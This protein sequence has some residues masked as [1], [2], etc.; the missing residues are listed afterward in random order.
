M[1]EARKRPCSIC[2]KWF[3][4]NP[5]VGTRQWACTKP[6]CQKARRQRTQANWR[7]RNPDYFTGHRIQNRAAKGEPPPDPSHLPAP[8][9]QLPW[10][11]AQDQFG[12]QSADFI[13]VMGRFLLSAAQDRFRAYVVDSKA[14]PGTFPPPPTQD[15]TRPPPY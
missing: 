5:R 12:A 15:Q 9:N 2:R 7:A 13:R 8:L 3:R 6:D 1:P 11:I 10:D 4:P 14:L